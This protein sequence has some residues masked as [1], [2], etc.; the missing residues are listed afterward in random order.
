ME[1]KFK[2][3]NL[4]KKDIYFL[5]TAT[6]NIRKMSELVSQRVEVASFIVYDTVSQTGEVNTRVT[7]RTPENEIYTTSSNAFVTAFIKICDT[8]EADEIKAI[9]VLEKTSKNGRKYI[10]CVYCD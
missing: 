9:K 2:S 4:S 1:A 10:S 8:F 6:E 5:T 3:T 7:L